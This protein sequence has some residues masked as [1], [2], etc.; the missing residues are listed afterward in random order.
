[1]ADFSQAM[2]AGGQIATGAMN[3]DTLAQQQ[4]LAERGKGY[5]MAKEDLQNTQAALIDMARQGKGA[6]AEIFLD[7]LVQTNVIPTVIARVNHYTGLNIP[8]DVAVERMKM[9]IRNTQTPVQAATTTGLAARAG[10]EATQGAPLTEFQGQELAKTAPKPPVF[11][12]AGSA[13]MA[14]DQNTGQYNVQGIVPTQREPA[15]AEV[16]SYM[17]PDQKIINVNMRDPVQISQIPQGS[18]E[19]SPMGDTAMEPKERNVILPDGSIKIMN[20]KDPKAMAD[21]PEGSRIGGDATIEQVSSTRAAELAIKLYDANAPLSAI[22]GVLQS[23]GRTPEEKRAINDLIKFLPTPEER[24]KVAGETLLA[25]E[26]PIIDAV[27]AQLGGNK[28]LATMLRMGHVTTEMPT[29]PGELPKHVI[30]DLVKEHLSADR[31]L[32]ALNDVKPFITDKTIG[33]I[34]NANRKYGGITQ[35][36][37]IV[38]APAG[39]V[40]SFFGS[41]T[42]GVFKPG[43]IERANSAVANFTLATSAVADFLDRGASRI[44]NAERTAAKEALNVLSSDSAK[45][46][47]ALNAVGYVEKFVSKYRDQL[48][49]YMVAKN[50]N[51]VKAAGSGDITITEPGTNKVLRSLRLLPE[52]RQQ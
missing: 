4:Q 3:A 21:L 5:E 20:V 39:A 37:G 9:A 28:Q 41:L 35:Y 19:M 24:G 50:V 33:A 36:G 17:T 34:A 51:P 10:A 46:E 14:P 2:L 18:R 48:E 32:A 43:D 8:I 7:R 30:Q 12:P 44:S 26:Q 16:K 42:A 23:L 1:M 27:A 11:A 22:K 29:A 25:K 45:R 52:D 13:I 40:I 38:G 49:Q 47:S 31:T 15:A 6:E